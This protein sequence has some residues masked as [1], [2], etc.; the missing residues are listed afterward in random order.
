MTAQC[1]DS[2]KIFS[3]AEEG[4]EYGFFT[5][6]ESEQAPLGLNGDTVRFVSAKKEEPQWLQLN[7]QGDSVARCGRCDGGERLRARLTSIALLN[8]GPHVKPD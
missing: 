1:T 2:R 6:I 7:D 5:D 4:Y 3:L 8:G